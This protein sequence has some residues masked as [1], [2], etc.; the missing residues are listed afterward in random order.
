MP[1]AVSIRMWIPIRPAGHPLRCFDLIEQR[2]DELH[3]RR[4]AHLGDQDGV[5]HVARLLDD[6]DHVAV[7]P[8]RVQA[9]HADAHRAP[10]PV[11]TE[12][13]F[14]HVGARLLLVIGRDRVLEVEEDDVG[15]ERGRLRHG[16]DVG[17]GNGELTAVRPVL[18]CHGL[19]WQD[20]VERVDDPIG[21]L[22]VRV[23]A[24]QSNAPDRR[25]GRSE[26]PPTSMPNSRRIRA[27]TSLPST[28]SGTSIAESS[29]S[30]WS[31]RRGTCNRGR[32]SAPGST[33]RRP[34]DAPTAPRGPPRAS[35]RMPSYSA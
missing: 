16:P 7:A 13:R 21:S 28:P 6:L 1:L 4:R 14:D 11:L 12:E 3:V 17:A 8:V 32:A 18:A 29:Q 9:V 30:W 26:P 27:C 15:P 23:H 19:P 2:R 5:E 35:S 33:G 25:R 20:D 24:H 10:G 34:R 31:G 22:A